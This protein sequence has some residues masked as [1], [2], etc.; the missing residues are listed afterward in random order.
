MA[1]Q[2]AP[3][4]TSVT[5]PVQPVRGDDTPAP[6][7]LWSIPPHLP[8]RSAPVQA[9]RAPLGAP[10]LSPAVSHGGAVLAAASGNGKGLQPR[11]AAHIPT[12]HPQALVSQLKVMG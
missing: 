3:T 7:C 5:N 8:H 11:S 9:G 12:D 2:A 4:I 1:A 10:R 6:R